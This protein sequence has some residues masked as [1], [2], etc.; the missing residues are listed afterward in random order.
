GITAGNMIV[1]GSANKR[2]RS[3]L[4]E[5]NIIGREI[6][7][8]ETFYGLISISDNSYMPLTMKITANN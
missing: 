5:N 7:P 1:A 2:F 4:E 8:G 3:E 6:K